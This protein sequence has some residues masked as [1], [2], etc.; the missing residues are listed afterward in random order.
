SGRTSY[1]GPYPVGICLAQHRAV[2]AQGSNP[3]PLTFDV[4]DRCAQSQRDCISQRGRTSDYPAAAPQAPDVTPS[5][6][7]GE[8]AGARGAIGKVRAESYHSPADPWL[9]TTA[10]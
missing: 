4:Q 2:V 5:P 9:T 8:R 6:L 10:S 7:N 3:M 1:P